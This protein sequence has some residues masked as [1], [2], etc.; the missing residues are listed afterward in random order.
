MKL[1]AQTDINAPI[2]FVFRR[3]VEFQ[4]W[5]RQAM[6]RGATVKRL[7]QA[8][9]PEVGNSWDI[10]FQFR[11]KMRDLRAELTAVDAPNELVI[12]TL[13]G[14]ISG[15]TK[16]EFVALS[17]NKTRMLLG[18]EMAASSLAGRLLLQ[19]LRL[20]QGRIEGRI[21]SRLGSF[22]GTVEERWAKKS[23]E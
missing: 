21:S 6:R 2:K 8:E 9:T 23:G 20:G 3:A 11:G 12:E 13:S 15:K 16:I 7:D 5:E 4:R 1:K 18:T 17:P 14:G 10:G 22:A 19:S